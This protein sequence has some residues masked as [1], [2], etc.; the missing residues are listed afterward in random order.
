MYNFKKGDKV[1][2]YRFLPGTICHWTE[3]MKRTIPI[4]GTITT[5][6]IR[7]GDNISIKTSQGYTYYYPVSC[8]TLTNSL[9]RKCYQ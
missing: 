1:T 7:H 9:V 3:M 2:V 5:G 4:G 6:K 8:I